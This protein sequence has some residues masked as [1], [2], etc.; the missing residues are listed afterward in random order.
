VKEAKATKIKSV[1]RLPELA[2]IRVLSYFERGVGCNKMTPLFYH[3]L[4]LTPRYDTNKQLYVCFNI[5]SDTAL[6]RP[7]R[8]WEDDIKMDLNI[9]GFH[10]VVLAITI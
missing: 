10:I 5:H 3:D 8:R 9:C 4:L 6:G 7:M 1:T 2:E